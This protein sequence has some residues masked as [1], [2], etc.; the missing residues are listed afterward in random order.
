MDATAVERWLRD[1]VVPAYDAMQ[2][3]PARGIPADEVVKAVRAYHA[4]G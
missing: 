1:E 2:A 3:H 4:V